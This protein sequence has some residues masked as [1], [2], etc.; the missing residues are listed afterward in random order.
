MLLKLFDKIG[1][2]GPL[3]ISFYDASVTLIPKPDKDT[4]KENYCQVPVAHA[5]NPSYSG[6]RDQEDHSLKP[7][8]ANSSCDSILKK[9]ITKNWTGGLAQGE[10]PEFKPQFTISLVN[11]DAKLLN[12]MLAK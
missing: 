12:E 10:S 7:A 2:E 8:W 3:P 4:N 1:K 5:C 6:G 9:P 11:L